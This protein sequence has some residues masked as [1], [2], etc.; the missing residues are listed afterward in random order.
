M[1]T[2]H[3]LSSGSSGN[4]A[5]IGRNGT[6]VLL[7]AGI[8][9]RRI[10]LALRE[11]GLSP[12]DLSAVLVT[13]AHADHIAGLATI[14]K[15]WD[16]PVCASRRVCGELEYRIAGISPRLRPYGW[17]ETL[18]FGALTALPFPTSHD[19]P[20]SAGYRFDEAGVLTDTG[21]V[22]AEAADA[23]GG[24]ALLVLEANHDTDRLRAGPYPYY[25]K[26]RILSGEGHLSNADA[27]AFAVSEARL[28]TEEI[29][30]AHLSR[31][32]NTPELALSA[33]SGALAA[34]GLSPRLSVAP[35]SGV[36]RCY[37]EEAASCSG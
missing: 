34:A 15:S 21:Y 13:H 19:A 33:V 9:C 24:A 26:R 14:A 32:N 18:S 31:E 11:L 30:L 1:T 37:G 5:L 28:G 25:L 7:D 27:A 8:S 36:S 22:T 17:E 16:V 20:G 29:V 2:I 6:Y 3:T 4:A 10:T 35:R 23:L 12:A